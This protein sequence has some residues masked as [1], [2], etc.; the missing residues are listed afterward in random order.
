MSKTR[1]RVQDEL[2]DVTLYLL[3]LADLLEVDL[4]AAATAKIKRRPT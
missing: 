2:A 4:L 3:R 1:G